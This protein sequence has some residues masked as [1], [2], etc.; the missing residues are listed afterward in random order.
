MLRAQRNA[1][2]QNSTCTPGLRTV[3]VDSD[4]P[5]AGG[6]LDSHVWI[7]RPKAESQKNPT[8][9][10]GLRTVGVDRDCPKP[11]VFLDSHVWIERPKAESQKIPRVPPASGQSE[12]TAS[13]LT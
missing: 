11:T 10:P 13:F 3:G 6:F 8:C 7:E 12:S 9:T 5:K 1:T 4:C 2:L